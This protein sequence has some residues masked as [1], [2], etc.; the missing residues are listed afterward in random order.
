M[1]FLR[2]LA[3]YGWAVGL[4]GSLVLY[5]ALMLPARTRRREPVS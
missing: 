4:A 2:H 3:D 1:P 5:V